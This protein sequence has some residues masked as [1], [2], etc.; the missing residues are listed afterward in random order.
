[1][2]NAPATESDGV[3]AKWR[4]ELARPP[5]V[6]TDKARSM[7]A[8]AMMLK[9]AMDTGFSDFV[10]IGLLKDEQCQDEDYRLRVFSRPRPRPVLMH[11]IQTADQYVTEAMT[12]RHV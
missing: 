6:D 8:G 12:S 3:A 7:A 4:G 5:F 10:I 2:T 9:E 11:I 1:M